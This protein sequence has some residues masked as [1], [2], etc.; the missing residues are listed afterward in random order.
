MAIEFKNAL[1]SKL[2][3]KLSVASLL[4]GPTISSLAGEALKNLDSPEASNDA[5]LIVAKNSSDESPLSY[6]QQALLVPAPASAR[7]N[8]I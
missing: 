7:R 1:E 8:F 5:P 6:G 4:Q 3:I 2:G